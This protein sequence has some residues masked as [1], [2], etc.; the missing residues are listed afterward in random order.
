MPKKKAVSKKAPAKRKSSVEPPEALLGRIR[1]I[2]ESARSHVARSVNT[3]QVVAN[4][5]VGREIVV[6]EQQGSRK[7]EYGKRI[8]TELSERLSKDYGG[9][10]SAQNL[11]YMRQFYLAYPDL[12]AEQEILHAVRGELAEIEKLH[13]VRGKSEEV[14]RKSCNRYVAPWQPGTL[15]PNLSWTHYRALL[16]VKRREIRN[17]YETEAAKNKWSARE[18][19]RQIN[20]LLF[21]R[22]LKSR[23]KKGVKALANKGLEPVNPID[24]IKDPYVLEF[25]DLPESHRLVESKL[26]EALITRLAD[27]LLELGTGFAFV[28]RQKRLTLDGDHYYSDL[29]FYHVKLKCYLVI[30]LKTAKLTHGDLGQMQMYVNYYDREI[31]GE[32]DNPTI[33][34]ILCTAKNDAMVKYVL[35]EKNKQIFASRYQF[36]LPTEEELKRELKHEML[37]LGLPAPEKKK[38][39]K[40]KSK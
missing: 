25:L 5:L 7:A 1:A 4:W 8:I 31:R 11:F 32:D 24:A 3:T 21:E 20:S 6:E 16:K 26:E 9:G 37:E 29:V 40:R 15:S 18:L 2:L 36:N 10:Y 14:P 12:L 13:A 33:G 38:T 39:R 22:L 34:L 30:D 19:E 17:F 28:A 23:D 35:D 27:F